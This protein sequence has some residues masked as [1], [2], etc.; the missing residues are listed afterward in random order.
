MKN[1]LIKTKL[2]TMLITSIVGLIIFGLLSYFTIEKLKVNG[3]MYKEIVQGKD[4]VADILPP[5]EY[6]IESYLVTLEMTQTQTDDELNKF[7]GDFQ[8]LKND[9]Y[10]RHQYW[11]EALASGE[12]KT[13]MVQLSY[14]SA[15]Q[16][17]KVVENELI[18]QLKS[19]NLENGMALIRDKINPLYYAH[20]SA[21]NKV[22]ELANSQNQL[23]ENRAKNT[24][25]FSYIVL[26]LLLII[27]ILVNISFSYFVIVSI[28]KPLKQGIDFA[29]EVAKGNLNIDF[30][31]NQNDEIGQLAGTLSEMVTQLNQI[32][33]KVVSNSSQIAYTSQQFSSASQQLSKGASE[34]AAS[35]EEVSSSIEE[36]VAGI[37]QNAE[38]AK[39]TENISNQSQI[40]ITKL[41]DHT[42]KIVA[43]NRIIA[44]KITIINDIAFQTNILALNA[45]VEA[46][47]AGDQGRGFAVVAVEVRKL[48]ERSKT[49]ADE[50]IQLT[51]SNLSLTEESSTKMNQ[52]VPDIEQATSLVREISSASI[53][54]NN[55]AEQINIA[56]QQLNN[57]TQQN[58]AASEELATSAEELAAQ[59]EQLKEVMSFFKTK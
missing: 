18:P 15:D 10:L 42:Q 16:F 40:G 2:L 32:V 35:I 29:R 11:N 36:M 54:Q 24:I 21:I 31:L 23:I 25:R 27:I 52:L 28:A 4:L 17:Y 30:S 33:S 12:I 19:K 47:R 3:K 41:A 8:K 39:Q 14:E 57:V 1:L 37:Q 34:Q 6:I 56:I 44:E 51:Q 26:V 38:N 13:N 7:I 49:A 22:V 46:A 9:Y 59:A 53:E 55:G 5:P 45:A 50:I 43:S 58:A 48:A 20:R